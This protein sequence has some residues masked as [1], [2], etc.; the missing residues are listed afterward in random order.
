MGGGREETEKRVFFFFSF[1]VF[2]DCVSCS[3]V[4]FSCL[5]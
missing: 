2:F 5:F 4:F 1:L 3:F